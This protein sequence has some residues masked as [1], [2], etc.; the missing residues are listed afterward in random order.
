MLCNELDRLSGSSRDP[1]RT[2]IDLRDLTPGS[3]WNQRVAEAVKSSDAFLFVLG[4][5]NEADRAQH[6]E[7]QQVIEQEYYLD[8][9]KPLIPVLIGNPELPG[10]LKTRK[11]LLFDGTPNGERKL[12]K[13]IAATL[14][15]PKISV[16]KQKLTVARNA[17]KKAL[18]S[19]RE[20]SISLEAADAKQAGIRAIK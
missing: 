16:D 19:L 1:F 13:E 18:K 11:T 20:Y 5:E 7:W 10:F 14:E 3:D 12:A 6:F 8:P 9:K 2:W 4:P 15:N 17:R